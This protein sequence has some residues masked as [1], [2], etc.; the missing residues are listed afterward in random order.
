MTDHP[1]AR[2]AGSGATPVATPVGEASTGELVSRLTEQASHL[3][4]DELRLAQLEIQ[5]KAKKVGVGAGLFGGAGVVAL[6]GVGALVACAV[7]A[8]ATFLPAWLSALI[9]GVLLLIVA[10][11][12]ALLGKKQVAQGTPPM[13][14]E[15][16][17]GLKRDVETVKERAHR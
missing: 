9:V 4:R 5:Q 16:V 8:L 10:G 3:I 14:Q 15:A 1:D 17:D 2:T 11:V 6:Y 12:L 7:L 13:P